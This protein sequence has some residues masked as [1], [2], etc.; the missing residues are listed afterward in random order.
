MT[1]S[2]PLVV[3]FPE[4]AVLAV[5]RAFAGAGL[6]LLL[7]SRLSAESRKAAGWTLFGIGALTTIPIAIELIGRNSGSL[8]LVSKNASA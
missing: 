1:F 2:N 6:G 7:A 5:T 8:N 3:S 4:L